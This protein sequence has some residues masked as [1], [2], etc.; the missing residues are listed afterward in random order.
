M[1]CGFSC[2][3]CSS[4]CFLVCFLVCFVPLLVLLCV[5][6][7]IL[8]LSMFCSSLCFVP[9]YVLFLSIRSCVPLLRMCS[10]NF[11]YSFLL[12]MC[13]VYVY[14]CMRMRSVNLYYVF[15]YVC[16]VCMCVSNAVSVLLSVWFL[17]IRPSIYSGFTIDLHRTHT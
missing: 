1:H 10:V 12:C 15:Y 4:P 14:K 6:L 17:I 16:A 2:L 13:C 3:I 8:F 11:Y 9:L 7:S 5:F